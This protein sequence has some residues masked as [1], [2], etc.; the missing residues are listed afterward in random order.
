MADDEWPDLGLLKGV[1]GAMLRHSFLMF[2]EAALAPLGQKP[3]AHHK[4]MIR[5]L[6][7]LVAGENRRLM[8]FL[9]P[10]AA[11]STYASVLFPAW[12]LAQRPRLNII[13]ACN[14][15][16]LAER[17]SKSVQRTATDMSDIL[18]YCP[19]TTSAEL[20]H[21]S[22]GSQYRAAG[23]GGVVT[24]FRADLAVIDDPI[25]GR[26]D[27]DSETIREKTWG[28][29]RADLTTRMRPGGRI[30]IVQTRW[31]EAD[32]AGRL[33]S[34]DPDGWRVVSIP[35][36][37]I[38]DDPLGRKPGEWLWSDD[39]YGYGAL[40][41]KTKGEFE[42]A[43]AMLDWSALYQQNPILGDGTVFDINK[44]VIIDVIPEGSDH[45]VRAWDLAATESSGTSN[46]D[47]TV[48]VKMR[49]DTGGG[50]I[51]EDVQRARLDADGVEK[52]IVAT[53]RA[54]GRNVPISLPQDPGQAGKAQV[55]YLTR[56]LAG[57]S[58]SSSPE[59]GSKA[60]RAMPFAAQVNAG[61][62]QLVSAPWNYAYKNELRSFPAGTKDDQ[63][64][65]SSRAFIALLDHRGGGKITDELMSWSMMG[66]G[67]F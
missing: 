34:V 1:Q 2:C 62:V 64:D 55:Q 25:R 44:L 23:V 57:F 42:Q 39:D 54:D 9:P 37:A 65:A 4:L 28:W 36:Q 47:W 26:E 14:T 31:H 41:Q 5:E 66:R 20:W 48:G 22:N 51:I 10:G 45:A 53:A 63:V 58:V 40:L 30:V 16:T 46:A 43:C 35:A 29:Y 50:Y 38:E 33:L 11:K 61:N 18:G 7:N 27:A 49:R 19:V 3:A 32:L 17:F 56:K 67:R 6:E 52:L 13:G 24:G 60:T 12:F 15:S 21:G 8:L 59:T